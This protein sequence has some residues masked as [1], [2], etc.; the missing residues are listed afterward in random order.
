VALLIL[1]TFAPEEAYEYSIDLEGATYRLRLTFNDR[2]EAWYVDLFDDAG[3]PLRVGLKLVGDW[4]VLLRWKDAAT[5]P[6]GRLLTISSP[7]EAEAT[8]LE[9]LGR[10][11]VL[12]Y[13]EA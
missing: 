10:D 3:E 12:A 4:D 8:E 11:V 2:D 1:P 9:A 13:L 6:P 5:R 7:S